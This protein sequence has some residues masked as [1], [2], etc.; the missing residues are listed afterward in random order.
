[1]EQILDAVRSNFSADLVVE[2]LYCDEGSWKQVLTRVDRK[3]FE[4][5]DY[6]GLSMNI[7][8]MSPDYNGIRTYASIKY[9]PT[10]AEIVARWKEPIS[11]VKKAYERFKKPIIITELSACS[12]NGAASIDWQYYPKVL[13]GNPVD[14]QEQADLFEGAMRA[15]TP[16]EYVRGVS[17]NQWDAYEPGLFYIMDEEVKRGLQF[18]GK[19]AEKVLRYWYSKRD[20]HD[21]IGL[22]LTPDGHVDL[23][24]LEREDP[25]NEHGKMD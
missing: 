18:Q 20:I 5:M 17:W 1:M 4:L 8:P 12:Y 23:Q 6:M 16:L 7:F 2:F 24:N 13:T 22:L 3:R 9:D 21:G 25:L 10:V 14:F 19:P 15:L 11:S